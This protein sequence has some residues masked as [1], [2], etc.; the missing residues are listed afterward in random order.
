M[1]HS[2]ITDLYRAS[3]KR[4]LAG[5]VANAACK[6]LWLVVELKKRKE[7]KHLLPPP[8]PKYGRAMAW[9]D[10]ERARGAR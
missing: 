5:A 7:Q 8:G 3:R 6:V 9:R 2:S 1:Q 4:R 10:R